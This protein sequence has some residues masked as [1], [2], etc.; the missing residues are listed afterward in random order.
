[1]AQNRLNIEIAPAASP[2]DAFKQYKDSKKV[3]CFAFVP[4]LGFHTTMVKKKNYCELTEPTYDEADRNLTYKAKITHDFA[5]K[6]SWG[7]GLAQEVDATIPES[8]GNV[9]LILD[10]CPCK[11]WS[12]CPHGLHDTCYVWYL[13][14]C[15]RCGNCC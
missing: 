11:M 13:V 3:I 14:R 7:D 15:H 1:M 4:P 6:S 5:F 2:A 8:F 12:D 10:D 9:T